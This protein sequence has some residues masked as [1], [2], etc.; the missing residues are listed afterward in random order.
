[1]LHC[2][3]NDVS[4]YYFPQF[5]TIILKETLLRGKCELEQIRNAYKHTRKITQLLRW[6]EIT[7]PT[8]V[9]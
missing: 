3:Y 5:N 6:M 4:L 2:A 1:M 7:T 8:K 9:L